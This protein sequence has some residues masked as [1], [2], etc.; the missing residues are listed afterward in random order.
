M[1]DLSTADDNNKLELQVKHNDNQKND[2]E[3]VKLEE[4]L[5]QLKVKDQQL[6]V[7][8]KQILDLKKANDIIQEIDDDDLE[9]ALQQLEVKD[10]QLKSLELANQLLEKKLELSNNENDLFWSVAS[11][12]SKFGKDC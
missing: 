4:S 6:K 9:E 8:D 5:R 11:I 1:A 2:D 12:K 7:K 10:E 3:E